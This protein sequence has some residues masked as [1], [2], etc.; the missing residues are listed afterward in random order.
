VITATA[1]LA[2]CANGGQHDAGREN[3]GQTGQA[4]SPASGTASGKPA[5]PE[6][7]AYLGAWVNPAPPLKTSDHKQQVQSGAVDGGAQEIA[8]LPAFTNQIQGHV[9]I[10][11][12]YSE[13][14]SPLP[15]TTLNAIESYGATPML[16]WSCG[17]VADITAGQDDSMITKYADG[18]RSFGK[19]VFLRW[20]W[21]MNLSDQSHKKCGGSSDP[22]AFVAAWRHIWAIFQSQHADN[23]AFVWCPSGLPSKTPASAYYPGDSYVDWIGVD[24]YDDHGGTTTGTG[25]VSALFGSWYSEWSGHGK[26]MMI[27]ETGAPP[28]DQAGF[29]DGLRMALP[30]SYPD[31]KALVYFDSPGSAG[32]GPYNL[33]GGG[34]AA[35]T[36][37]ANDSYFSYGRR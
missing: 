20:Y 33:Q 15:T 32:K 22:A 31:I 17:N 1:T 10:L 24:H 36:T 2:G 8:Q 27:G 34:V 5:V 23:V 13:F 29:L 25:A 12:V 3:T 11:H 18:L 35:F 4:A 9:Q 7:G 14:T 26:P 16:D 21:E 28:A 30:V 6:T 37:L 19:P